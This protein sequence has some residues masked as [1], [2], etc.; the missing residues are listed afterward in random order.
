MAAGSP[1]AVACW[2]PRRGARACR[3]CADM[4]GAG[5][6]MDGGMLVGA[7]SPWLEAKRLDSPQ[8]HFQRLPWRSISFTSSFR[9]FIPKALS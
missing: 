9:N 5:G 8:N 1:R 6:R 7:D 2:Q 3:D 4:A